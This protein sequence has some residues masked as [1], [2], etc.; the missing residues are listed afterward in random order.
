MNPRTVFRWVIILC[1]FVQAAGLSIGIL[2]MHAPLFI[3]AFAGI[4]VSAYALIIEDQ[5]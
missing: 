2:L 4:L 1:A 3:V 5:P